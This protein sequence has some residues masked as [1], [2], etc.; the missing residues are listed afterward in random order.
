MNVERQARLN[1]KCNPGVYLTYKYYDEQ[2]ESERNTQ[3]NE[4]NEG[5]TVEVNG[6]VKLD[7]NNLF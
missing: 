6:L 4:K 1:N 5:Q 3:L 7:A 2:S